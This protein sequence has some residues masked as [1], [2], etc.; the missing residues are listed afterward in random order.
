MITFRKYAIQKKKV[1]K[2]FCD[3]NISE[4]VHNRNDGIVQINKNFGNIENAIVKIKKSKIRK[5]KCHKK[6]FNK[7]ISEDMHNRNDNT[8]KV[9]KNFGNIDNKIVK[10]KKSKKRMRKCHTNFL[11]NNKISRTN[12]PFA[13]LK[14]PGLNLCFLNSAIQLILSIQPIADLLMQQHVKNN[15]TEMCLSQEYLREYY[16]EILFLYEF[17]TL[18]VSMLKNLTKT[19]LADTLAYSFQN[20]G[21]CDYIFGE[22]WDC[23]EIIDSFFT[24]YEKFINALQPSTFKLNILKTLCSIKTKV[25]HIRKCNRCGDESVLEETN[26]FYYANLEKKG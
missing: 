16:S 5:I 17:E 23:S 2:Y 20:L 11:N 13:K 12:F 18:A 15:F 25:Q 9:N 4:D 14:N 10:I 19:F 1:F 26:L 3:K 7:S 8:V 6:L 21:I 24:F 22:Q